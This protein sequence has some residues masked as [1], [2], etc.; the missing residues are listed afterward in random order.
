MGWKST[1]TLRLYQKQENT[2]ENT[3]K[4]AVD[5]TNNNNNNCWQILIMGSILAAQD[6][7]LFKVLSCHLSCKVIFFSKI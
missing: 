2:C 3:E 6:K 7:N 4:G 1:K 5:L